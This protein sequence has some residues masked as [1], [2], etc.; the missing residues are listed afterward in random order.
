M[1]NLQSSH[2]RTQILTIDQNQRA[3]IKHQK[4]KCLWLT[5]LSGSGKSTLANQLECT[6][7]QM[8]KHT[9]LLDGDNIRQHLNK[10]LGFT[11]SDREENIRR[12]SEV[13]K[14]M[15]DAGLIVIVAFISPYQRDRQ[16]ARALFNDGEFIEIFMDTPLEVCE[17]RDEKGLYAKARTGQLKNFTG[18]SA[19]YE[20]PTHPEITIDTSK[21]SLEASVEKILAKLH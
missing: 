18:I 9:Y 7:H 21:D 17:S 13:A 3:D 4:A 11:E 12:I 5:G 14:L 6:L 19:P 1:K 8:G 16:S 20:V 10:D 2:L 15:V